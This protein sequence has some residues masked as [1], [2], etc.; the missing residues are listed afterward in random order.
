MLVLAIATCW[1]QRVT[2][3]MHKLASSHL[4]GEGN[5]G[6]QMEQTW[7]TLTT[8]LPLDY[9][10]MDMPWKYLFHGNVTA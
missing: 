3:S 8:A 7:G 5:T 4:L 1:N 2:R 6:K 10:N 9:R